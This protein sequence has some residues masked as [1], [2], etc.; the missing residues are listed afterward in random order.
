[1]M[2]PGKLCRRFD[3]G[4]LRWALSTPGNQVGDSQ[5]KWILRVKR[6]KEGQGF[7]RQFKGE[8]GVCWTGIVFIAYYNMIRYK[9]RRRLSS[10]RW[11]AYM[12]F[13]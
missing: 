12:D 9:L 10:K 5:V 13:S 8:Q 6:R 2:Q 1:M 11:L 3:N 4:S 7:P